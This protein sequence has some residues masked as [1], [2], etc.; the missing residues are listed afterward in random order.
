M[1][2]D[3][4]GIARTQRHSFPE[5]W[6]AHVAASVEHRQVVEQV[7]AD[8]G[9]S[10]HY[11]FM[12]LMSAGIAVLGLLLSSPAVVIGAMLI[13]PL[14]EPSGRRSAHDCATGKGI[15]AAVLRPPNPSERDATQGRGPANGISSIMVP[16]ASRFL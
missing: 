1:N 14:I 4:P 13:S 8:A 15:R 9:W 12:T 10:S 2:E 3:R 7:H 16:L 6:H 11:I 5:W